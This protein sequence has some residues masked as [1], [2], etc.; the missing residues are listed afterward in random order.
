VYL[1]SDI[2]SERADHIRWRDLRLNYDI[3]RGV[4]GKLPAEHVQLYIYV[5][6]ICMLWKANKYGIDPDYGSGL[7][8]APRSVS[9]GMVIDF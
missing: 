5:N 8:P 6:N 1:Y 4:G 3:N 7:I 9:A 2:L